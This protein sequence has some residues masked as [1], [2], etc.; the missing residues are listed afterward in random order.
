MK[1][2]LVLIFCMG[3]LAVYGCGGDSAT[4]EDFGKKHVK[5]IFSGISCDLDDLDITVTEVGDS[6]A[7][8]V[9]EGDIKY[10]E[11][12]SLIKKGDKWMTASEAAKVE[13]KEKETRKKAAPE[14][15]CPTIPEE[16]K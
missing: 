3:L 13:Q 5:K 1:K 11:T 12:L 15:K 4:P 6:N 2:V 8:I 16:H 10:K 14:K 9:I 7:T